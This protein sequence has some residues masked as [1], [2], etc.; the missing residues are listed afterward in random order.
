MFT[1]ITVTKEIREDV[2]HRL[3]PAAVSFSRNVNGYAF[4]DEIDCL[5][6]ICVEGE[7]DN[8]EVTGRY[9]LICASGSD[10]G[11]IVCS[12]I[13]LPAADM[14]TDIRSYLD[15]AGMKDITVRMSKWKS[16]AGADEEFERTRWDLSFDFDVSGNSDLSSVFECAYDRICLTA[17]VCVM[18]YLNN[19]MIK[20]VRSK[21]IDFLGFSSDD[22]L[23]YDDTALELMYRPL[24]GLE[25][26]TG[27]LTDGM[28]ASTVKY[29]RCSNDITYTTVL[30][31][32]IKAEVPS[33]CI[34]LETEVDEEDF[35]I[36][37]AEFDYRQSFSIGRPHGRNRYICHGSD[38]I[39]GLQCVQPDIYIISPL[40]I[41]LMNGLE[42]AG[43]GTQPPLIAVRD[44]D[45]MFR[46]FARMESGEATENTDI[47]M[48][49]YRLAGFSGRD[50]EDEDAGYTAAV[51][52]AYEHLLP[53][54]AAADAWAFEPDYG[55]EAV[56]ESGDE[57]Q[58]NPEEI[59]FRRL[60]E[61]TH[62]AIDI[63]RAWMKC[64]PGFYSI[65][66]NYDEIYDDWFMD[67]D[68]AVRLFFRSP[69][70]S[71]TRL[72]RDECPVLYERFV[73]DSDAKLIEDVFFVQS[74]KSRSYGLDSDHGLREIESKM[75]GSKQIRITDL[76]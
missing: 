5:D 47:G 61:D 65:K 66:H 18:L 52:H 34:Y 21:Y 3:L 10:T 73:N 49:L 38:I 1:N 57:H 71:T 59:R 30:V 55:S 6:S 8:S 53:V 56:I 44:D 43:A 46:F 7:L 29:T 31:E 58:Q 68:T 62:R 37:M 63:V 24:E 14:L 72:L 48:S 36:E 64:R 13:T 4:E 60:N 15:E 23:E 74:T 45:G 9:R 39:A 50:P 28:N 41:Y 40:D 70:A 11:H 19:D 27:K 2:R 32:T 33:S 42:Y 67:A 22:M 35:P 17:E 25:T 12:F 75:S 16:E 54:V 20:S 51:S 26:Y 76:M 69:A